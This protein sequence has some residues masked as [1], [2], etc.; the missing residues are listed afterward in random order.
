MTQAANRS[1]RGRLFSLQTTSDE[2]LH[3][4]L[5]RFIASAGIVLCHSGEFFFERAVRLAS[6]QRLAGLSLFVDVFFIISGFVIAHVYRDRMSNWR[7]FAR[8]MQRRIGRLL[9]LH[10][11]TLAGVALLFYAVG[12]LDV[13]TNTDMRLVP[14]CLALGAV[15]LQ[16]VIDCG[17]PVP[18][19][20]SWSISAEMVMYVAFPLLIFLARRS[21]LLRYVLWAG[22]LAYV[23]SRYPQGKDWATSIEFWRALPAFF[24]GLALRLDWQVWARVPVPGFVPACIALGL[25]AGSLLLWPRW[26]LL[27]LAYAAALTA[28]IADGRG[29]ISPL[30]RRLAPLGQLTYSMYML[31]PIVIMVLVNAVGDKLLKLD[32]VALSAVTVASYGVIAVVSLLSY[33][34][35]ETPTRRFIDGL[36]LVPPARDQEVSRGV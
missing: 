6:H 26:M 21:G 9:P 33:K 10:L 18:N 19:G 23:A 12:A 4:D 25:I 1:N 8:F 22:F 11:A 3:L 28:V 24:F 36:R 5:L 30:T 17:G 32:P 35:F 20:V 27:I 15:L 2:L 34:L 31:H 7:Q 16:S 14:S 13:A 29:A